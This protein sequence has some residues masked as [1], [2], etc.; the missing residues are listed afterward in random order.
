MQLASYEDPKHEHNS[1]AFHTGKKCIEKS[2]K[3]LAGTAWSPF[4]CFKHNVERMNR[5]TKSLEELKSRFQA[6]KL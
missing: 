6:Q 3:E 2:C 5:I 4:W 1:A